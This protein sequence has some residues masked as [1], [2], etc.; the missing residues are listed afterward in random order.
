MFGEI[1]GGIANSIGSFGLDM[2]NKA[3]TGALNAHYSRELMRYQDKLNR[4]YGEDAASIAKRGYEKADMNPMLAYSNSAQQAAYT[5]SGDTGAGQQTDALGAANQLA[6]TQS[7][8]RLQ[9]KQGQS[10]EDQGNAAI[11]N[12]TTSALKASAEIPKILAD[13]DVSVATKKK[14]KKQL[15]FM[16]A[17]MG[18]IAVQNDLAHAQTAYTMAKERGQHFENAITGHTAQGVADFDHYMSNF[19]FYKNVYNLLRTAKND[20]GGG[21]SVS[22]SPYGYYSQSF[23]W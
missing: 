19:P 12:A 10:V 14:L 20:F 9:D 11:L 21:Y 23:K 13:K 8:I 1:L 16:D 6:Q 5:A 17:Q 3:A 22:K 7:N 18:Q 15:G 4:Q 2:A